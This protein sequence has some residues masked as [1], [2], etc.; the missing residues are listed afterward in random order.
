MKAHLEKDE[1]Q[2]LLD[3]VREFGVEL[4]CDA[5]SIDTPMSID[6]TYDGK[7]IS[8]YGIA[9]EENNDIPQVLFYEF[10]DGYENEVTDFGM[11]DY[12]EIEDDVFDKLLHTL[13]E[14]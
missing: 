2:I 13:L 11:C 10:A 9:A 1:E 3:K 7:Q 14:F 4:I 5:I 6:T 8:V 12:T